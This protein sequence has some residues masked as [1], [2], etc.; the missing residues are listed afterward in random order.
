MIIKDHNKINEIREFPNRLVIPT[1]NVTTKFYNIGYLGIK[2]TIGKAKFI[3]SRVIIVHVSNLKEKLELIGN[4][5][6][7]VNIAY[8]NAVNMKPSTKLTMINKSV[9][10]FFKR[11]TSKTKKAINS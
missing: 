4:R 2:N 5:R 11:I 6:E 10:Y 3:I 9:R 7:R 8:I 1:S